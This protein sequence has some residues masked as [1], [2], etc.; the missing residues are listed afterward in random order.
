MKLL[1]LIALV[2]PIL[3]AQQHIRVQKRQLA[4]TFRNGLK[5]EDTILEYLRR[6]A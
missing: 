6:P 2:P 5:L 4:Q 3:D 1:L